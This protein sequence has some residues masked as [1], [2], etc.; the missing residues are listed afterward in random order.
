MQQGLVIVVDDDDEC[1]DSL[2][3]LLEAAGFAVRAYASG[4]AFL[5]GSVSADPFQANRACLLLD[6]NLPGMNGLAVLEQLRKRQS[7]LPVILISGGA[8]ADTRERALAAGASEMLD[9]PLP[10][11]QLLGTIGRALAGPA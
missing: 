4:E 6:F 5:A 11:E 8:Q 10:A 7:S 1:R 3:T 2:V 9:K